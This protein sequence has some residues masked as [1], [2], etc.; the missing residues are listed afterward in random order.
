MWLLEGLETIIPSYSSEMKDRSVVVTAGNI[1]FAPSPM[2]TL[3]DLYKFPQVG[4][5][6]DVLGMGSLFLPCNFR[7]FLIK[8]KKRFVHS[9]KK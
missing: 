3:L 7:L 5:T 8:R 2:D 9:I 1:F 4:S 6:L